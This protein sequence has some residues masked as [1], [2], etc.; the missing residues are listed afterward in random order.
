MSII[1]KCIDENSILNIVK[2][3][4]NEEIFSFFAFQFTDDGEGEIFE[5]EVF[6]VVVNDTI[7]ILKKSNEIEKNIYVKYFD[8]MNFNVPIYYGCFEDWILL[9]YVSGCDLRIVNDE[10]AI[11]SAE[12]IGSILSYYFNH[13]S[14]RKRFNNYIN[15]VNK[16][17]ISLHNEPLLK[18]AYELFL[19]RQLECP[20]SLCNGDFLQYNGIFDDENVVI[21]DW[22][23]GGFLPYSIDI[24]RF[25]AHVREDIPNDRFPFQMN[26]ENCIKYVNTIYGYLK[27]K[28]SY[29]QY[30]IDIKLSLLN[31]Y[32]E[33]LEYYFNN[34]DVY[35][36][37]FFEHY[38]NKATLI[39]REILNKK[40]GI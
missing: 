25:I 37:E 17:Y 2:K 29:E 23:F 28:I 35:K 34:E 15:R 22:G 14:E 13:Q 40:T 11:K 38:Y 32:V 30:I 21:I 3:I 7:F 26:R 18:E 9:E 8:N 27:D 6:K 39:A 33:F 1:W 12:S 20:L 16:R 24:G 5:K 10:I 4:L 19:K 31:E 36:D